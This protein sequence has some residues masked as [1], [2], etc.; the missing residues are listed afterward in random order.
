MEINDIMVVNELKTQRI[1]RSDLLLMLLYAP[2]SSNQKCARTREPIKGKTRLQKE[3]FLAQKDLR[4]SGI[5]TY[6]PFRPYKY[7]PYSIELYDDIDFM[8]YESIITV[9]KIDLNNKG[10][11]AE[12]SITEKGKKEI[13]EKIENGELL[14]A[15]KIIEKIKKQYNDMNIVRLVELTHR[16][17]PE[18]D[19]NL[20][21]AEPFF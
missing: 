5:F 3:V 7:G 16:L 21:R 6:Y 10:K 19:G 17:Y 14:E 18:Y 9:K 12:F 11:Y 4:S 15:Y 20:S 1:E 13:E 2:G 8:E